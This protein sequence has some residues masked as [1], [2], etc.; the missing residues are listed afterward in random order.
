MEV[1]IFVEGKEDKEFLE[2][3]LGNLKLMGNIKPDNIKPIEGN[4]IDDNV[5]QRI[6]KS[7]D[8]HCKVLLIFDADKDFES[9]KN[10]LIKQSKGLLYEDEIFLFPNNSSEGELETLLFS[11]VQKDYQP[12]YECF[13]CYK[14]CIS[15]YNQDYANNI[16]KKSVRYAFFEALG[17]VGKDKIKE[18]KDGYPKFFDF[19]SPE[20]KALRDFLEKHLR[21]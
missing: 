21:T 6:K 15:S 14:K 17:L 16:K 2:S 9:T 12:I 8:D 5:Y 3:F 20:L 13:K 7:K 4:K 18:R 11:I 10:D 1:V 19:G